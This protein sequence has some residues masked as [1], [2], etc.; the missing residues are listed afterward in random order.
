M[1]ILWKRWQILFS[2][3]LKITEDGDCSYEIKRCLLLGR[4]AI[5]N[6]YCSV[7]Q[8]CLIFVTPWPAALQASLSITNSWSLLKLTS[9]KSVMPSSNLILCRP[10]LLLPLI[11]PSIRVFSNESALCIKWPKY[12]GFSFSI[13]PSSEYSGL[14]SFRI[15]WFD[16]LVVQGVLKNLLQHC[17]S[18]A[19]ILQCSAFF[20]ALYSICR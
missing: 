17:S 2:W 12:W 3:G 5:T 7:A 14:I 16:L 8:L 19:S 20:M 6:L 13:S 9:I 4:K 1:S 11:P 15:D 10:F 18:E